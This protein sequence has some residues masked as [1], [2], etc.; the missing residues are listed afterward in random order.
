MVGRERVS[1]VFLGVG[2]CGSLADSLGG[3]VIFWIGGGWELLVVVLYPVVEEMVFPDLVKWVRYLYGILSDTN[4]THRSTPP[5]LCPIPT[6]CRG[7]PSC[8]ELAKH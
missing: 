4:K 8:F 3:L 6:I 1:K 2:L 7:T 5:K